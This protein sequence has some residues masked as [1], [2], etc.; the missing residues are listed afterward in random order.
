MSERVTLI[1]LDFGTTTSSAVVAEADIARSAG[2]GR[3]EFGELGVRYRSDL[4][5]TPLSPGDRLDLAALETYIGDWLTAGAVD[6]ATIFGGGALLTGLTAQRENA[7]ALVELVRRR[8]GDALIATADDPRLESWLA[9]MG[10][11]AALSRALPGRPVLNL[12]IGGGT[13]NLALGRAGEVVDTACLFVGARHVR[14]EPGAYRIKSLSQFAQA[15]FDHLGID[16]RRGDELSP[17]ELGAYLD[18]NIALLESAL[19]VESTTVPPAMIELLTQ[20]PFRRSCSR[21]TESAP[22]VLT[23]T[24]GVG[25]LVYAH[26]AGRPW[27]AT[28][29][30]GDLGIDMAQRIVASPVLSPHI[31][32]HRPQ[33]AGRATALGL[34]RHSTEVSGSTLFL[35]DPGI[36]PLDDVPIFGTIGS[37]SGGERLADGLDLVRHSSRG[38]C[39]QI[40]VGSHSA[41]AVRTMG[42]RLRTVL[43]ASDFPADRLLVL[44]VRENVG[45]TL[46]QYVTNWGARPWHVVVIDEVRDRDARYVR[47]GRPR[48]G[49][50]PV[51][52]YGLNDV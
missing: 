51:S 45:K 47:I 18:L 48:S 8:L 50:V 14:V 2:A 3:I 16:R 30:F 6:E 39:L 35:P 26:A 21:T 17:R 32:A 4:R 37:D 24:G 46:G 1:G 25:E 27:P 34:M 23:F 38:G 10:S 22:P 9:F 41:A 40:S 49:I 31:A 43:A 33:S 44:L 12:D 13:T 5:I 52:F 7:R 11:C 28:T 20:S 19:G 15:A 42:E 29:A 36:L